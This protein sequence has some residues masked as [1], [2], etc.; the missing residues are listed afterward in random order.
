MQK[1]IDSEKLLKELKISADHHEENSR[2]YV[3]M[4]RDRNI[5]REQQIV[6]T[7]PDNPTNGDMIKA[8]FPNKHFDVSVV[9]ID[10]FHEVII[11]CLEEDTYF[12][13]DWWNSPYKEGV[14]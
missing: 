4:L 8:L 11:E 9:F 2:D 1:L 13:L 12:G 10:G 6:L 14:E 7:I 3:L 5:V